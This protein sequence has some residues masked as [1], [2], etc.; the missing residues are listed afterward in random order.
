MSRKCLND[1][2]H[3][4]GERCSVVLDTGE[5]VWQRLFGVPA[6]SALID[7]RDYALYMRSV[8]RWLWMNH[9]AT[10][11]SSIPLSISPGRFR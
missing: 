4:I 7:S 6:I 3:A 10:H 11:P 5:Y 9:R 2:L 8:S 1:G